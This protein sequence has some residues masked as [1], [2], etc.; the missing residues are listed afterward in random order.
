M[1]VYVSK[2]LSFREVVLVF[3]AFG[4]VFDAFVEARLLPLAADLS[5]YYSAAEGSRYM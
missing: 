5:V 3:D 1:C 4:L 2:G